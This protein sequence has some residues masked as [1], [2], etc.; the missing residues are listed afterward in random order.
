MLNKT[1]RQ[2]YFSNNKP[3]MCASANTHG[4][5]VIIHKT[6]L[7]FFFFFLVFGS[8]LRARIVF[9]TLVSNLRQRVSLESY[10]WL[11]TSTKEL[12]KC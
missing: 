12:F 3:Y 4:L 1:G 10:L 7:A 9:R 11:H 5:A 8:Q 6:R 2:W